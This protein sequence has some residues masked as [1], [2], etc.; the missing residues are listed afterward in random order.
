MRPALLLCLVLVAAPASV[1]EWSTISLGTT[2]DLWAFTNAG[3]AG[4]FACGTNGTITR[5]MDGGTTWQA[6]PI[7]TKRITETSHGFVRGTRSPRRR[8]A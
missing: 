2:E 7:V 3:S 4:L 5:S 1:Q 6:M 8:S